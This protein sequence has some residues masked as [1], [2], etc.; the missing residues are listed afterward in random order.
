M[1]QSKKL[2]STTDPS[3]KPHDAYNMMTLFLF[4][5]VIY[6]ITSVNS[7]SFYKDFSTQF[8]PSHQY[9]YCCNT[10]VLV[11][12]K[13]VAD[14]PTKIP[15][16]LSSST[17]FSAILFFHFYFKNRD[18]VS[19]LPRLVSNWAHAILPP[20]PPSADDRHEPLHVAKQQYSRKSET[21]IPIMYCYILFIYFNVCKYI[22]KVLSPCPPGLVILDSVP[23]SHK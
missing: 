11:V 17:K 2:C 5:A 1:S 14:N 20:Q 15:W 10:T 8:T 22:H 19:L 21:L 13:S 16:P 12:S 4:A 18:E 9:H 23:Q 7:P 6:T 3:G